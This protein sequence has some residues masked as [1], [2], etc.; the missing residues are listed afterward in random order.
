MRATQQAVAAAAAATVG[1]SAAAPQDTSDSTAQA[2][3]EECVEWCIAQ[4]ECGFKLKG[5]TDLPPVSWPCF[6]LQPLLQTQ[7]PA[8]LSTAGTKPA[9]ALKVL[10]AGDTAKVARACCAFCAPRGRSAIAPLTARPMHR[11]RKWP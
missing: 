5:G 6:L 3:F 9:F 8:G 1:S 7:H 11:P 2:T 4:I 10:Q